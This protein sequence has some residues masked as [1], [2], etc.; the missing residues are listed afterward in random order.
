MR[1][2]D[3][4]ADLPEP[5]VVDL[6]RRRAKELR[7]AAVAGDGPARERVRK[8]HPR[9]GRARLTDDDLAAFTL[10][11]AQ[12]CVARELGFDGWTAVL[13]HAQGQPAGR[14]WQRWPDRAD[15]WLLPRAVEV[16]D[17]VGTSTLGPECALGALVRPPADGP[18][19]SVLS[20]LGL[21][22][23]R[24]L[25]HYRPLLAERPGPP[26]A[27]VGTNPAWHG[28]MGVA[29]GIA[30]ASGAPRPADEHVLLALAYHR[31]SAHPSSLEDS[32]VAPDAVVS[33][34]AARGI[35]VSDL[36]PPAP[37][38][39]IRP[40]GPRVYFAPADGDAI[41][42]A[43]GEAY[44]PGSGMWGFNYDDDG[45]PYVEGEADLD[46]EGVARGAV[47][48]PATVT[49]VAVRRGQRRALR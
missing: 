5:F 37:S 34:L 43:L 49:A 41:V 32:G 35:A 45:R 42:H 15:M 7:R 12:L 3:R 9:F 31:S 39:V 14:P 10:R 27:G 33:E 1:P 23:A 20:G 38:A 4:P 18:A 22:W 11:D 13:A 44:P 16:A 2:S 25:G 36:R 24:W 47:A 30:L 40:L 21:T 46:L 17:E 8:A 28:L 26:R 19:A 48:D 6:L 29:E